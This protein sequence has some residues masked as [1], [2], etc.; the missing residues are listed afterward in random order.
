MIIYFDVTDN[1]KKLRLLISSV[2]TLK[3]IAQ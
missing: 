2:G 1:N 3:L